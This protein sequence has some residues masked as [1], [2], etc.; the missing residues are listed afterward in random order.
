MSCS[1]GEFY[2]VHYRQILKKYSYN[3]MVLYLQGKYECQNLIR[4]AFL[5]ENNAVMIECDYSEVLKAEFD[6]GIQ[7]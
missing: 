1:I 6:M 4:E 3:R 2:K 5:A 7:S